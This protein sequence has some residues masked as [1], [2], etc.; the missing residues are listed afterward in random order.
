MTLVTLLTCANCGCST[1]QDQI[2]TNKS[3]GRGKKCNS[4]FRLIAANRRKKNYVSTKLYNLYSGAKRRAVESGKE[5]N[6][7]LEDLRKLVVPRCPALGVELDWSPKGSSNVCPCSPSL[8]RIDSRL[9]YVKENIAII[10]RRANVIKNDAN[11]KELFLIAKWLD[12]KTKAKPARTKTT[13]IT[14]SEKQKQMIFQLSQ[15]GMTYRQIAEK[16]ECSKSSV[17]Y[18]LG[19]FARQQPCDELSTVPPH[20]TRHVANGSQ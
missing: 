14:L 4:C 19:V 10:S 12:N 11:A 9:G 2:L 5:F 16:V 6:I 8:D 20:P 13:R 17:G 15:E 3:K 18:V 1:N 7:T